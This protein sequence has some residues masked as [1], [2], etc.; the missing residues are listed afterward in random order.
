MLLSPEAGRGVPK[1]R[2]L[3]MVYDLIVS[4]SLTY[5]QRM[6]AVLER[7]GIT[8]HVVRSPRMIAP[9]GCSYS[10]KVAQS[11]LSRVLEVLKQAGLEP[12]HIFSTGDGDH[13]EE[14]PL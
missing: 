11:H 7:S 12:N 1:E 13:Y 10:V 6:A 9:T 5:A 14:V 2:N 3:A 4:R 8:A